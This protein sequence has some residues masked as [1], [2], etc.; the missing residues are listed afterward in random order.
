MNLSNENIFKTVWTKEKPLV[1][2]MLLLTWFY[3][4]LCLFRHWHFETNIYDLGNFDQI[5]WRYSRFCE[6]PRLFTAQLKNGLGD[7]FSP[8]L[9]VYGLLYWICPRP[10]ALLVVQVLLFAFG[11]NA[12]FFIL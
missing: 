12:Y 4:V 8:I 9:A 5:V 11:A 6:N 10:E 1:G 7:H 2:L 3:G